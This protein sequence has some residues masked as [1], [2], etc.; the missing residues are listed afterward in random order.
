MRTSIRIATVSFV[1]A[2]FMAPAHAAS[3]APILCG[4]EVTAPGTTITLTED[5][6]CDGRGIIIRTD[7][8]TIDLGGHTLFGSGSHEYDPELGSS[9]GLALLGATNTRILNGTIS[10]FTNGVNVNHSTATDVQNLVIGDTAQFGMSLTDSRG[11]SLSHTTLTG[12]GR[13]GSGI[14]GIVGTNVTDFSAENAVISQWSD[15]GIYMSPVAGFSLTNSSVTENGG[16][17]LSLWYPRSQIV[18]QNSTFWGNYDGVQLAH[19]DTSGSVEISNSTMNDNAQ[20]GLYTINATNS[21]IVGVT[22]NNN[23]GEGIWMDSGRD[24]TYGTDIPFYAN[25]QGSTTNGNRHSGISLSF[26]GRW[27]V[28]GNHAEANGDSG[29]AFYGGEAILTSNTAK[30]NGLDGFTWESGS[31]GSSSGDIATSNDRHG[32]LLRNGGSNTVR[33]TNTS[34]SHNGSTGLTAESGVARIQ[35]GSYSYNVSDGIRASID[36]RMTTAD[37]AT[38]GTVHANRVSAVK[39]GNNG[40]AFLSGSTGSIDHVSSTKNGRY[41]V[42]VARGVHIGDV[43]AHNLSYNTLGPRGVVCNGLIFYPR[44]P[45]TTLPLPQMPRLQAIY[46]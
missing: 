37:A 38:P 5:V 17:G 30:A 35:N 33:L 12:S 24:W 15:S 26:A 28:S 7:N 27:W 10:G 22:A 3:A 8:V 32:V 9:A 36:V 34:A 41:G 4:S 46:G 43:P 1:V 19:T 6:H 25:I 21:R 20:H 29:F 42:C 44:W 45:T 23:G 18:I 16:Q 14:G 40:I 13:E 39:N 31:R 11:I 2:A